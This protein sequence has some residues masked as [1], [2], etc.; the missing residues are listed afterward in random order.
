MK[1][2]VLPKAV[3]L[4]KSNIDHHDDDE[5]DVQ[6]NSSGDNEYGKKNYLDT[7]GSVW[8]TFYHDIL[9]TLECMLFSIEVTKHAFFSLNN[10]NNENDKYTQSTRTH[11]DD[12]MM[13]SVFFSYSII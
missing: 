6:C 5:D 1:S 12:L 7:L 4:L 10:N 9:S 3:R 13:M 11:Y 8:K 2:Q